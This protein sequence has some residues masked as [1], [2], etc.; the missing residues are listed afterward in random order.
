[1]D[2][3][4]CAFALPRANLDP[5]SYAP[6][7]NALINARQQAIYLQRL[8]LNLHDCLPL[9]V[10]AH[11]NSLSAEFDFNSIRIQLAVAS[12]TASRCHGIAVVLLR[13]THEQ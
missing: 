9:V 2:T 4:K 10:T 1:M 5:T 11:L 7:I 3:K 6:M 8:V 13:S 12:G